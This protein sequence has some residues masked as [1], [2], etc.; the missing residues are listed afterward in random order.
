MTLLSACVQGEIDALKRRLSLIE[1]KE[2]RLP[3]ADERLV[4]FKRREAQFESRAK[5]DTQ[6]MAAKTT[7]LQKAL[8]RSLQLADRDLHSTRKLGSFVIPM[9]CYPTICKGQTKHDSQQAYEAFY[10]EAF[11]GTPDHESQVDEWV[12]IAHVVPVTDGGPERLATFYVGV[13][14]DDSQTGRKP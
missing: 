10:R 3:S 8:N 4:L 11:E 5:G 13:P 14:L 1:G 2:G 6:L 7:L 9:Q 12:T